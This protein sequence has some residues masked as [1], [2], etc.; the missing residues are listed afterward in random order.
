[1]H[2]IATTGTGTDTVTLSKRETSLCLSVENGNRGGRRQHFANRCMFRCK[3]A[4][5]RQTKLNVHYSTNMLTRT[6]AF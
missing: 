3:I 2:K 6:V 1:M 5:I 4:P